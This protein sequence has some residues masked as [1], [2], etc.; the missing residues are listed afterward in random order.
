MLQRKSPKDPAIRTLFYGVSVMNIAKWCMVSEKTAYKYKVGTLLP[1]CRS[2][3]L[4][5]LH[6]NRKILGK[7]W[8]GW[9]VRGDKLYSPAN[10]EW[11]A[12]Q[13]E[14][15]LLIYQLAKVYARDQVYE[16]L[17]KLGTG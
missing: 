5:T 14:A 15:H 8:D 1:S 9:I 17:L 10:E 12:K 7:E 6:K 2:V 3:Y 16:V 11:S 13:L 4:F